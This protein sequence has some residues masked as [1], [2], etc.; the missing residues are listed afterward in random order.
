[1]GTLT[2]T[3][4]TIEL[5]SST[6]FFTN[7]LE[8][9]LTIIH[10][11]TAFIMLL[12]D[13]AETYGTFVGIVVIQTSSLTSLSMM[14]GKFVETIRINEKKLYNAASLC[15]AITMWIFTVWIPS[16]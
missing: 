10:N 13:I 1:M 11:I 9:T 16:E 14:F 4:I 3:S 6:V 5:W 12:S 15:D 7:L 8:S 2:W